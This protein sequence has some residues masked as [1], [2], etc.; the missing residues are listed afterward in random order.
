[1]TNLV[2]VYMD[3]YGRGKR[4]FDWLKAY[5]PV[6]RIGHTIWVYN[7]PDIAP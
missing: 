4:L 1:V 2:G 6:V 5:E 3:P 7:I